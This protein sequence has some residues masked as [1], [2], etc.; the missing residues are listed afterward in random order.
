MVT[1]HVETLIVRER[2]PIGE[3]L[4]LIARARLSSPT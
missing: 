1:E 3:V 4:L 2:S